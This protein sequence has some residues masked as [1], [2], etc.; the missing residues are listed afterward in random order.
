M[1]YFIILAILFT[2]VCHSQGPKKGYIVTTLGD[3]IP[4]S[5]KVGQEL[6]GPLD[7]VVFK[8]SS[9]AAYTTYQPKEISS[10][11]NGFSLLRALKISYNQDA[12]DDLDG[13]YDPSKEVWDSIITKKA[14]VE[15]TISGHYSFLV[16]H[17]KSNFPLFYLQNPDGT[18]AALNSTKE[19]SSS[20]A[21]KF[22][23]R[24][25][26][27]SALYIA[28]LGCDELQKRLI[29]VNFT[30]QEL[31]KF[32]INV[33]KCLEKPFEVLKPKAKINS[34]FKV[35]VGGNISSLSLLGYRYDFDVPTQSGQ[36][37]D[38]GISYL[39]Q[40]ERWV[41]KYQ[42]RFD[43]DYVTRL[44][45]SSI[46]HNTLLKKGTFHFTFD[47][48]F[49]QLSFGPSINFGSKSRLHVFPFLSG[50]ILVS[51]N[52]SFRVITF[53]NKLEYLLSEDAS[54]YIVDVGLELGYDFLKLGKSGVGAFAKIDLGIICDGID[55]K[56]TLMTTSAGLSYSF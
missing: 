14:F 11:F 32:V 31:E 51:G 26:Y 25:E 22:F 23:A 15:V 18:V 55:V 38:L 42:I 46:Y 35:R 30:Q 44:S 24:K 50:G 56:Y 36:G 53:E 6:F 43:L 27:T 2:G 40:K 29:N 1:R 47:P 28:S 19:L 48:A 20:N 49:L 39:L 12:L 33:N 21:T 52:E 4:G 45:T 8:P 10:A 5:F 16:F 7:S 9:E 37:F 17:L 54:P 41:P 3:T 13:F 34:N